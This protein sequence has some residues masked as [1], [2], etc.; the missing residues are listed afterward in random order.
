MNPPLAVVTFT[1]VYSIPI[2][3]HPVASTSP[4][5]NPSRI[6]P[7]LQTIQLP[8]CAPSPLDRTSPPLPTPPVNESH[9]SPSQNGLIGLLKFS[10]FLIADSGLPIFPSF[11]A[12]NFRFALRWEG[13]CACVWTV[14]SGAC[15]GFVM[16]L[17]K[18]GEKRGRGI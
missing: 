4:F 14:V 5:L 1:S 10:F 18:G 7:L 16:P 9:N 17:R 3:I 15:L 11:L 12:A 2:P 8:D 13:V 6:E